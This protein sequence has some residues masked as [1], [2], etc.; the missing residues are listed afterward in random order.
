MLASNV[1][2][3]AHVMRTRPAAGAVARVPEALGVLY[4]RTHRIALAKTKASL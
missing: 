3:K 4:K 2:E 1:Q